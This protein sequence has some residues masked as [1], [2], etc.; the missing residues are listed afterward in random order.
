MAGQ[1]GKDL[2]IA[3]VVVVGISIMWNVIAIMG[4]LR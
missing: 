3:I 1:A 4:W 2:L